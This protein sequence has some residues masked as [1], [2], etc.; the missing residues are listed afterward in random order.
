MS[1]PG[2]R[3]EYR[4]IW[5]ELKDVAFSQAWVRAATI[6]T[7]YAEAG[8]PDAPSRELRMHATTRTLDRHHSVDASLCRYLG[9][10]RV[11]RLRAPMSRFRT[12]RRV[13][14]PE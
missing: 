5:N 14:K 1:E 6:R 10:S 2:H 8:R 12:G 13:L 9:K 4:S 7:R 3:Q 11:S